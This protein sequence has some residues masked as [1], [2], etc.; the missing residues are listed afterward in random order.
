MGMTNHTEFQ[1]ET[2]SEVLVNEFLR[3]RSPEEILEFARDYLTF[4]IED[5]QPMP[6]DTTVEFATMMTGDEMLS[7]AICSLATAWHNRGAGP[8]PE[9]AIARTVVETLTQLT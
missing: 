5:C 4:M 9:A 8:F 3:T 1:P 6:S 2:H 7:T